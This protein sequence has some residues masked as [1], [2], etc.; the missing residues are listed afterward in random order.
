MNW[1]P[2]FPFALVCYSSFHSQESVLSLGSPENSFSQGQSIDHSP[3]RLI[4][5]YT[6]SGLLGILETARTCEDL[7]NAS[8]QLS[9]RMQREGY[10]EL[11]LGLH[12]HPYTLGLEDSFFLEDFE[13]RA[14]APF[15]AHSS[16]PVI[17][18]L[19][20]ELP[21]I[22]SSRYAGHSFYTVF[23]PRL[24]NCAINDSSV[25]LRG[26]SIGYDLIFLDV[27]NAD[28]A[29]PWIFLPSIFAHE[30]EHELHTE[31]GLSRLRNERTSY[32]IEDIVLERQKLF[33][34]ENCHFDLL[35]LCFFLD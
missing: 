9:V 32:G 17:T 3:Q 29:I 31:A 34:E 13:E 12:H 20:E 25:S 18:S 28:T 4:S 30:A 14:Y 10:R 16:S 33:L 11:F 5:S 8:R 19:L 22:L 1:E 7:K 24:L 15:V 23:T 27:R 21:S 26:L 6:I 35:P 2:F